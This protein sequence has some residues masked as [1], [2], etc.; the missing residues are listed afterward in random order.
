MKNS[1]HHI[2]PIQCDIRFPFFIN[3]ILFTIAYQNTFT[4]TLLLAAKSFQAHKST[5]NKTNSGVF[6]NLGT[7]TTGFS[8]VVLK[9]GIIILR[10]LE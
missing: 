8:V 9:N 5:T 3:F 2:Y 6:R 4:V 7:N 10:Q 1:F